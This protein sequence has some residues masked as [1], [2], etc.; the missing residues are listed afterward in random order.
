MPEVSTMYDR[1]G[2]ESFFEDLTQ[3]FYRDV[4]T[5]P[6]LRRIYPEETDALEA[7]RLHLKWFLIQFWGGPRIYAERRGLPQLRMRHAPFTITAV[8]RD[9]WFRHMSE[10]VKTAGLKPLDEA[11]MLGYFAPAATAMINSEA[12]VNPEDASFLP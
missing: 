11:Q 2:G 9:A 8:E 4:A 5:D 10:A 6:V 3:R 12:G 1:V 7:A